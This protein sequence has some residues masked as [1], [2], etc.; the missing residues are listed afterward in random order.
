MKFPRETFS[1]WQRVLPRFRLCRGSLGR[2]PIRRGH[3]PAGQMTS[4][5]ASIGP[6]GAPDSLEQATFRLARDFEWDNLLI[7]LK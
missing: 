1:A 2:K 3:P 4:L 5:L 7:G 6:S